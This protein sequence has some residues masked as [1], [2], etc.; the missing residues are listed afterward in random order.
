MYKQYPK[1][2]GADADRGFTVEEI[3]KGIHTIYA[4]NECPLCGR[5]QPVAAGPL[6][7]RCDYRFE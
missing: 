2:N 5:V 6:C 1:H 7:Q 3:K 4:D